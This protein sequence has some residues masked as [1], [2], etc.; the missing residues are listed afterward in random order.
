MPAL[1]TSGRHGGKGDKG[2]MPSW[3][4]DEAKSVSTLNAG[5]IEDE[6][7]TRYQGGFPDLFRQIEEDADS[8]V[9]SQSDS[10]GDG[11]DL[12]SL[13]DVD[14]HAEGK[15]RDEALRARQERAIRL[16]MNLQ[17][18]ARSDPF[19]GLRS[20]GKR[21][22]GGATAVPRT[23]AAAQARVELARHASSGVSMTFGAVKTTKRTINKIL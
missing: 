8:A 9:G 15:R 2:T 4:T 11:G 16:S 1:P 20:D 14:A 22:V 5:I 13:S 19:A 7:R 6:S 21:K 12:S 3:Y 10:D 23:S 17:A 18:R